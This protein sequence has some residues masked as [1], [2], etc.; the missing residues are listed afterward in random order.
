MDFDYKILL[1]SILKDPQKSF[2]KFGDISKLDLDSDQEL[3]YA[4]YGVSY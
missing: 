2:E 3:E 4:A 1:A